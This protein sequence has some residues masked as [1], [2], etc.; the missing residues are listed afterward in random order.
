MVSTLK[1]AVQALLRKEMLNKGSAAILDC[2]W[3]LDR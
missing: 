3:M 1:G 2:N